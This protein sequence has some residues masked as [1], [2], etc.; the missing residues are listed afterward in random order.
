MTAIVP[1]GPK[2]ASVAAVRWSKK[3][4]DLF[5]RTRRRGSRLSGQDLFG[6]SNYDPCGPVSVGASAHD[7]CPSKTLIHG[8]Y[9]KFVNPALPVTC[10]GRSVFHNFPFPILFHK[11]DWKNDQH[12]IDK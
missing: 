7:Q 2:T 3:L 9:M 10:S 4:C 8:R 12:A 11:M 1:H 6:I 5:I